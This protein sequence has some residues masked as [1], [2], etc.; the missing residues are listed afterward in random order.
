[1]LRRRAPAARSLRPPRTASGWWPAS[2]AGW[3]RSSSAATCASRMRSGAGSGAR[4]A[5]T[6]VDGVSVEVLEGE[7]VGLVG[8]SGAGK[9]TLS[10]MLVRLLDPDEGS[11]EL[12]GRD[13]LAATGAG[14]QGRPAAGAA[15]LPGSVRGPL[16]PPDGG[17]GGAGAARAAG[18]RRR[19][20]AGPPGPRRP[21]GPPASPPTT[22]S[23]PATRTSCRAASCNGWPWPGR[24]CSNPSCWWPTSP[25]RCST[26]PSR[27][28]CS[29]SSS[30][31]RWTGGWPWCW[32]PTTWPS[33]LRVA[34]RVLVMDGGRVVEEGT[35]SDAAHEAPASGHPGSTGGRRAR[36]AIRTGPTGR[37]GD[38]VAIG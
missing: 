25:S 9:S 35:G 31:S 4:N 13:L 26:P 7:V 6:A 24:W 17:P 32:S 28:R 18:H 29:S 38:E 30:S 3:C 2:G 21:C 15:A 20:G 22:T 23:W 5:V 14:A 1:M 16:R 8:A 11:V 27:P 10:S 33:V 37:D 19:R 34:D 12:E 36:P